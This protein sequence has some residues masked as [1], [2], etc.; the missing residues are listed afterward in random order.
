M[1]AVEPPTEQPATAI[2]AAPPLP[3]LPGSLAE[4]PAPDE[5]S[6]DTPEADTP[7]ADVTEEE[8]LMIASVPGTLAPELPMPEVTEEPAAAVPVPTEPVGPRRMGSYTGNNDVL[9][10]YSAERDKWIRMPP[11]SPLSTGDVLL[12]LPKFRRTHVVLADVNM[13]LYGGTRVRVPLENFEA[14]TG[15]S[16]WNLEVV[17]GRLLISAGLKG[18]QA[19]M[20]VDDQLREFRLDDSASLAVEVQR[21]FVAGSD[22][23]NEAAPIK[24]TWYLT[25]GSVVWPTA[26]GGTQTIQAPAMWQ[27]IDGIDEIPEGIEQLPAWIDHELVTDV[28]RRARDNL[29]GEL[30][31][32]QAVNIRLLELTDGQGL[33]R[34][35]EVRILAAAASVFVGEF[36]PL[37]KALN[38]SDQKRAWETHIHD[39]RQALALSPDVAARVRQDFV[40]IRGEEAARDLMEMVIGYS[41][42]QIGES[43]EM[44]QSGALAQLINWLDHDSL[45]YRVLA[46]HNIRE[47]TGKIKGYRPDD[48]SKRRKINL[49]KLWDEFETN[50][51]LPRG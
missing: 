2:V 46:I 31:V 45:D 23:E 5:T 36:E 15:E 9:L 18:S 25:S 10:I 50:E 16:E 43:R 38:D 19:A 27:T 6:I 51:L 28:E 8:P 11:R 44:V 14:S 41:A 3:E 13:D 12:T 30:A 4:V 24:A 47:I 34:Q 35:K 17:Y 29:A 33:G 20:Q 40:N 1:A 48:I 37:V 7:E 49:R 42:E 39:L 22:Y 26:A 21:I 32:N